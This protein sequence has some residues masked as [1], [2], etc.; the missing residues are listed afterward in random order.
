MY[1][2]ALLTGYACLYYGSLYLLAIRRARLL[3][4][5]KKNFI[6]YE[7]GKPH[8]LGDR[9]DVMEAITSTRAMQLIG[10]TIGCLGIFL[11]TALP[12]DLALQVEVRN[13]AVYFS[14]KMFDLTVARARRPPTLLLG[15]HDQRK[16]APMNT[17]KDKAWYAWLLLTE[18]RYHAFDIAIVQPRRGPNL[19]LPE[20]M[21]WTIGPL[22]SAAALCYVYP[23]AITK[24]FL[25]LCLLQAGLEGAHTVFHPRCPHR[26]FYKPFAAASFAGFWSDHWHA[27]ASSFFRSLAYEPGTKVGGRAFG[28]MCTFA[29]SGLWHAWVS[30]PMSTKPWQLAGQVW[31]LFMLW[32]VGCLVE[33]KIWSK[34]GVLS[35]RVTV[36]VVSMTAAGLVFRTL[37]CSSKIDELSGSDC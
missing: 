5:D 17:V 32:G 27:G 28:V 26:F 3:L 8:T 16:P 34:Q 35:Q 25:V 11:S 7:T 19:S 14:C 33:R 13:I 6:E 20:H 23:I 15:A 21:A 1:E 24:A 30:M 18:S 36:W 10:I 12:K 22:A 29:M 4:E 2:V 9:H 31:L 37:E